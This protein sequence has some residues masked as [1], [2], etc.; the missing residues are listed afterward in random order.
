MITWNDVKGLRKG[1]TIYQQ[2]G[3]ADNVAVLWTPHTIT[4]IECESISVVQ[5][6]RFYGREQTIRQSEF[7]LIFWDTTII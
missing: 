4:K 1:A 2:T 3:F 6:N 5:T 7:P